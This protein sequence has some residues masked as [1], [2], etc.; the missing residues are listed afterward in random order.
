[1]RIAHLA[2]IHVR[3]LSRHDEMRVVF[4]DFVYQISQQRVDHVIL[5]GDVWHTK[6]QGISPEAIDLICWMIRS[7]S[8]VAPVHIVLGN[9]DLNLN[10]MSRQ[11][12]LSPIVSALAL[13]NVHLYKH[14][15]V[16]EFAP[17]HNFCVF[18]ILDRENWDKV[19]PIEGAFNVA[20][21]H[22]SVWGAK[23]EL[24]W[25][26]DGDLDVTFFDGFDLC[27]LGD[28]HAQQ[29]MGYRDIETTMTKEEL[30]SVPQRL[31]EVID[32]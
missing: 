15:G 3:G 5:L 6:T 2:D 22:G 20:C 4:E 17:G 32:D 10:N 30:A 18:S 29:F 25:E 19:K 1:M 21:Y 16:Y 26:L 9:H 28:I 23:T 13:P 7:I 8:N 12:V 24:G 31:V 27:L 11:D 14:S